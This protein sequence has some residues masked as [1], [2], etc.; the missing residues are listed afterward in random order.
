M[1]NTVVVLALERNIELGTRGHN[2]K[3]TLVKQVQTNFRLGDVPDVK[4]ACG[5]AR[6]TGIQ[7]GLPRLSLS[8]ARLRIVSRCSSPGRYSPS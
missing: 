8:T 1:P 3:L 7:A 6:G 4:E 2:S 5:L